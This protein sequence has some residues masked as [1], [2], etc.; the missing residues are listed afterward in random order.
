[1]AVAMNTIAQLVNVNPAVMVSYE[2]P[3]GMFRKHPLVCARRQ[4]PNWQLVRADHCMH[5]SPELD[6]DS[7]FPNKPTHW[8]VYNLR[9]DAEFRKCR[10]DCSH[11]VPGTKVHRLLVCNRVDVQPGQ[12]VMPD[13]ERKSAIPLGVFDLL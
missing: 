5:T 13:D 8:L 11:L 2:N 1:M 12:Q 3:V 10:R 4:Q 9:P 7:V 6:G